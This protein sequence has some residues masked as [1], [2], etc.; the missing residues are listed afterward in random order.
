MS[1]TTRELGR[2]GH[3]AIGLFELEANSNTRGWPLNQAH[4]KRDIPSQINL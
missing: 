1:I 2:Q 3:E 4:A